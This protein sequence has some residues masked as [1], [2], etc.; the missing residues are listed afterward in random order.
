MSHGIHTAKCGP[1]QTKQHGLLMG[2]L[3]MWRACARWCTPGNHRSGARSIA[4]LGVQAE[5]RQHRGNSGRHRPMYGTVWAMFGAFRPQ[6]LANDP[7]RRLRGGRSRHNSVMFR[8]R[9]VVAADLEPGSSRIGRVSAEVGPSS[10]TGRIQFLSQFVK[11]DP[12]KLP[13]NGGE[14]PTA[15]AACPGIDLRC[16]LPFYVNRMLAFPAFGRRTSQQ[17]ENSTESGFCGA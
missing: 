7:A 4:P 8:R 13:R 10:T 5:V 3:P 2:E 9:H 6:P 17:A 1:T 11:S 14:A 15:I 16:R 12:W